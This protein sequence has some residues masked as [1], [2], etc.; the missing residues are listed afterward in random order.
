MKPCEEL[1][2]NRSSLYEI[3]DSFR[4]LLEDQFISPNDSS[5]SSSSDDEEMIDDEIFIKR[6]LQLEIDEIRRYNIGVQ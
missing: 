2:E 5:S 1:K 4:D 6:H 3:R